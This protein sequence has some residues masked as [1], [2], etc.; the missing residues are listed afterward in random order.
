MKSRGDL[1]KRLIGVRTLKTAIGATI[2]IIL[3]DLLGLQYAVS[4][5]IITILSVQAT[6]RQS[7]EIAAKR[8][9]ATGI[10]LMIASILFS[11]FG[12][13]PIVFG[14]YLLVFIPIA[15][16]G[17]MVDGI[18][19]ASVLVTHLLV[20]QTVEMKLLTNELLLFIIGAGIALLLNLYMP[21]IE[22]ELHIYRHKIEENMYKLFRSMAKS[23]KEKSVCIEEENYFKI[24][25]GDIKLAQLQAY[26]HSNNHL[27]ATISPYERY[28]GMRE[29]QFQVMEY[30]REHFNKFFMT[31]EETEIVA[32]FA[33]K[34]AHS[35]RG[36]V[37]AKV[38]LEEL[39]ELRGRF[40]ASKLPSTREE[41]EN[42]AMLY[43][44][45][46]DI[47]HFLEIKKEFIESLST[48]EVDIYR[49]GYKE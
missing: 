14:I 17:G 26:K 35:I 23:L 13:S 40:K 37:T 10:A 4:A 15:A 2:A 30:M 32:E 18:V 42:R 6:K 11:V 48:E 9:W 31:Y 29:K 22:G 41:F 45:L 19:M 7:I 49:K 3:A 34:V 24:L 1:I 44:Y 43:Q 46:N 20:E 21:S 8:L 47:E 39:E 38:L 12:Y 16:K 25:E 5:G 33:S 28:F 27:F 36:E